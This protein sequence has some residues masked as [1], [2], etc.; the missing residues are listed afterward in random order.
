MVGGTVWPVLGIQPPNYNEHATQLIAEATALLELDSSKC[1]K[2]SAQTFD[3]FLNSI[4]AFAKRSQEQPFTR[5]IL[6]KLN[7][8][9]PIVKDITLIKNAVNHAASSPNAPVAS[10]AARVATWADLVRSGTPSYPSTPGSRPSTN[11]STQDRETLVKLDAKAALNLHTVKPDEIQNLLGKASR[12]IAA[13]QLKSGD[14][15]LYTASTAEAETLKGS[16]DEWVKVLGTSAW[17]L[18][19]TYEVEWAIEKL[20]TENTSLHS[21]M[22][23]TYVGWLTREGKRK[24]TSSLVVKFITRQQAN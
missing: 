3:V 10:S 21:G 16:V 12:V 19:S 17:V 22:K 13:K 6:T 20:E 18:K 1:G 4:V 23:V 7:E 15:V 5:E 14:V 9:Q 11:T 8:L 24:P 2:L